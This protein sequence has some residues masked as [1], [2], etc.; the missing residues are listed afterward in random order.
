MVRKVKNGW[1]RTGSDKIYS[2][3]KRAA[4]AERLSEKA[5]EKYQK[6]QDYLSGDLT[7]SYKDIYG[8]IV[9]RKDMPKKSDD[10]TSGEPE[11]RG[12]Y[13]LLRDNSFD[14]FTM[15]LKDVV[16]KAKSSE[17]VKS[18]L[19]MIAKSSTTSTDIKFILKDLGFN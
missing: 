3:E 10:D 19:K 1:K 9:K 7:I 11:G 17:D 13:E 5:K 16:D 6:Y 14:E 4:Y 2:S 18:L 8:K 15:P 12:F